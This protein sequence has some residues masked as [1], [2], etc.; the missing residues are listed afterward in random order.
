MIEN[1]LTMIE[2]RYQ[3]EK[4][5]AP[6]KTSKF[7]FVLLETI[8]VSGKCHSPDNLVELRSHEG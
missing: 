2:G 8:R 7:K 1:R 6:M 5:A 3:R 4:S